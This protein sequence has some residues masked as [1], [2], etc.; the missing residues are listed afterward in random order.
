MKSFTVG[1]SKSGPDASFTMGSQT[2]TTFNDFT[3]QD[4]TYSNK[5]AGSWKMTPD[6]V[7][8]VAGQ[9][10]SLNEP[11]ALARSNFPV[12]EQAI[13]KAKLSNYLTDTVKFT[14]HVEPTLRKL[15]LVK[16]QDTNAQAGLEGFIFFANPKTYSGELAYKLAEDKKTSN[17]NC[18]LTL[19][20]TPLK[21]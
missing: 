15:I 5:V 2:E 11:P 20:L 17:L 19:D 10:A 7:S 6:L 21:K 18:E 12:Y 9:Y 8:K 1:V 16:N 14:V 4:V 13:F 3:F